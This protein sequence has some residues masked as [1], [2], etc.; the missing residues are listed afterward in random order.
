MGMEVL[1]S[2]VESPI[3]FWAQSYSPESSMQ[4]E[5]LTATMEKTCPTQP[6]VIGQLSTEQMYGCKFSEDGLWYRCIVEKSLAK[7]RFM[8]AMLIMEMQ[9]LQ[10]ALVWLHCRTMWPA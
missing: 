3:E 2:H 8:Y 10:T 6:K 7:T 9:R 4:L 1:V 5:D